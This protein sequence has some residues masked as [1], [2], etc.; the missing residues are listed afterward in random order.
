MLPIDPL[1]D[2]NKRARAE[3]ITPIF[4][5]RLAFFPDGAH[6]MNDYIETMVAFPDDSVHDDDVDCTSMALWYLSVGRVGEQKTVYRIE[7]DMPV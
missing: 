7:E 4:Q 3:S 2:A 5:S 6:W 1:P